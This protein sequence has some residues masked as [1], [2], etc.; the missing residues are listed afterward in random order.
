MTHG[1]LVTLM[2]KSRNLSFIPPVFYHLIFSWFEK[3]CTMQHGVG[4]YVITLSFSKV[5]L[6]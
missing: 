5:Y 6:F 3:N 4:M 1:I 2:K